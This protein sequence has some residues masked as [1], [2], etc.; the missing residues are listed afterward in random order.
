M[1]VEPP[2]NSGYMVAAYLIAAIVLIGYWVGL[3][4]RARKSLAEVEK[5][6]SGEGKTT[7]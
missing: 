6:V 3:W 7:A 1:Q 4:R 2:Q 5:S